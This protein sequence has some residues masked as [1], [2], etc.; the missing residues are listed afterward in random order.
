MWIQWWCQFHHQSDH[1]WQVQRTHKCD[2]FLGTIFWCEFNGDVGFII[3]VTIC[4]KSGK[5]KCDTFSGTIL[6]VPNSWPLFRGD[7]VS[8]SLFS[9]AK[10]LTG[11]LSTRGLRILFDPIYNCGADPLSFKGSCTPHK[12]IEASVSPNKQDICIWQ[13][14]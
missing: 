3:R 7:Q 11:L 9:V 1:I 14:K 13:C 10:F 6:R 5:H 2:T 4:G 12:L 8:T